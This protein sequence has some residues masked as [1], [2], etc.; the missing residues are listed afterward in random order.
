[1][2][3]SINKWNTPIIWDW[4]KLITRDE[5]TISNI[6]KIVNWKVELQ[7]PHF[8]IA[9]DNQIIINLELINSRE[10]L[11]TFFDEIFK[12]HYFED[13][14]YHEFSELIFNFYSYKEK[15]KQI[16]LCRWIKEFDND[17]KSKYQKPSFNWIKSAE[18]TFSTLYEKKII[19]WKEV[20]VEVELSIDEFIAAM[21]SYWLK[22]W[23]K[24]DEI[25]KA[26]IE[27]QT[28]RLKIAEYEDYIEWIDSK[29]LSLVNLW[30]DNELKTNSDW[31]IN[32]Q[33]YKRVFPQ[34]S[35]ETKIYQKIEKTPWINWMDI[36]WNI[37]IAPQVKDLDI[38]E[39]LEESDSWLKIL[40]ENWFQFI[41]SEVDWYIVPLQW[42]YD[43]K[44]FAEDENNLVQVKISQIKNKLKLTK[45]LSLWVIW[46]DTWKIKTFWKVKAKWVISTY[47]IE[48][49]D[50]EIVWEVNWNLY[51]TRNVIVKWNITWWK[52]S[53]TVKN[54][55]KTISDWEIISKEWNIAIIWNVFFKS[56]IKALK[57]N[58]S[59]LD[60]EESI[61]IWKNIK[62][63][64]ARKTIFIWD[65]ITI[66]WTSSDCLYIITK[67]INAQTFNATENNENI[68]F[69]CEPYSYKE[70]EK[71][72]EDQINSLSQKISEIQK[73]INQ[74][75]TENE[76]ILNDKKFTWYQSYKT[77]LEQD[78]NLVP[79]NIK[80]LLV[81]N[82][83]WYNEQLEKLRINNS[84][85]KKINPALDELKKWLEELKNQQI[86]IINNKLNNSSPFINV[87]IN[88]WLIK[89][90]LLRL[91]KY[92]ITDFTE[93]DLLKLLDIKNLL[94]KKYFQYESVEA[95]WSSNI[96][97]KYS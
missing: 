19:N 8:I 45:E 67:S 26:F 47:S 55:V 36:E 83:K 64:N 23:L 50:I 28:S 51:A 31:T 53:K 82:E 30:I 62:V 46:P 34:I 91:N 87:K 90:F 42:N 35:A 29:F 6:D 27:K 85:I 10:E 65:N 72:I 33:E 43:S 75:T 16:I 71:K 92:N 78:Q 38:R 73:I 37:I 70:D 4:N 49:W 97:W 13:L 3:D 41:V 74:I 95:T 2:V 1:M 5:E 63:K 21:W 80:K 44:K 9:S 59:L 69:V 79:E 57:W 7:I 15:N 14:N 11:L 88:R 52:H 61:V 86:S 12:E 89:M 84:K 24:I 58:I 81:E 96:A 40:D 18:Y 94:E 60:I 32:L 68:I 54:W 22:F 25:K 93:E 17:R 48:A 56:L 76:Q 77:K 66:E 39:L 20:E